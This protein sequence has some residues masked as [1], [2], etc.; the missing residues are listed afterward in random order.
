MVLAEVI[1]LLVAGLV[2]AVVGCF[3]FGWFGRIAGW[4]KRRAERQLDEAE[5]ATRGG[6]HP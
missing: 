1:G 2:V 6:D 5:R 4:A 3:L